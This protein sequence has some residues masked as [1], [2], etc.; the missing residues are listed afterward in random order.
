MMMDHEPS[1]LDYLKSL[2]MPW[3]GERIRI[4]EPKP[5]APEE[6]IATGGVEEMLPEAQP[7]KPVDL[8]SQVGDGQKFSPP[9]PARLAYR[10]PWRSLIA[11]GVALA[12]QASLEPPGKNAALGVALYVAAAALL[13]W[14]VLSREWTMAD[15]PEDNPTPMSLKVRRN[16]LLIAIPLAATAYFAFGGNRFTVVNIM[17]GLLALAWVLAGFYQVPP[18]L[19]G[20]PWWRRAMDRIRRFKFEARI[21]PWMVLLVLAVGLAFFFRF[22]RLSE[23]P[24]EM[25]SDHAEKLLDVADVLDGKTSIFFPRNTGREAIQFYLTAAVINLLGTGLSFI[26][27]KIGTALAGLLTLPY[28]YLLGKEIG[29]RWVGLVAFVLAAVGYWPNVVARIGLRFPLYALFAAPALYYLIRGLRWQNRNDFIWAG[30]ALGIGLHGYSPTRIL[31]FVFVVLVMIYLLHRQARGKRAPVILALVI[32]GIV[33]LIVLLPLVRYALE[34][35]QQMNY[36]G[37]RALSRLGTT[38]RELPGPAL[39]IFFTNLWK[40]WIMPFWEDGEIWVHSI[41]GRPSLDVITAALYFLGSILVGMRYLRQKHWIDLFLLVSVPLL[42]LPSVL[43]LAFPNENPSLN[44]TDAAFIPVFIIAA[45]GL[46]GLLNTLVGKSHL[47][48]GWVLAVLV[49]IVLLASSAS[50]NYNLVFNTFSAQFMR[51]AWNTSQIGRVIRG[52]ADSIGD[53]ETAFVIPYPHWV[54]TRLVGINAGYPRKDYAIQRENL[55][56]TLDIPGNKLFIFKPEDNETLNVLT[57]LYPQGSYQTKMGTYPGKDFVVYVVP[58][59]QG[60]E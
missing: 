19:D 55:A 12:A 31:P 29:G 51:G 50:Q 26:S 20:R 32:L 6:E 10:W 56:K 45:I 38:E 35:P 36:V 4:P 3:K 27:L 8:P 49:G 33:A 14:A 22:Y 28:I 54:D 15:L 52:F 48:R 42:M 40:A 2:L 44:R 25:F 7:H 5:T 41:P 17:L 18:P 59:R 43:S 34:S 24:G 11:V 39:Q 58:A 53:P 30:I 1:V 23:V 46:Q 9:P 47:A 57:Q 60:P 16:A 21:S 37:L 13:V